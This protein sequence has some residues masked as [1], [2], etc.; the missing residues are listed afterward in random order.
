LSVVSRN[1]E[2]RDPQLA[3]ALNPLN[4]EAAINLVVGDLNGAT[5]PNLAALAETATRLISIAPA[6]ARGY[7]ILGAVEDR[8]GDK[9]RAEALYQ[10]ALLHSKSELHALLSLAQMRLDEADT[11]AALEYIDLLLRRWP[12]YFESAQVIL[13]AAAADPKA[14]G[15]LEQKLN[16]TP[17]WR[18]TAIR[19]LAQDKSSLGML[20]K[21]IA[22][23]P[24]QARNAPAWLFER[25]T[26]VTALVGLEA[27]AEAYALFLS[28]LT[29]AEARVSAYVFDGGFELPL[30]RSFFGWRVQ[31]PGATEVKT[32]GMDA[33]GAAGLRVR[34]LDSPAR[35]AIVSQ[36]IVLPF[37][38]YKLAVEASAASL[39]APKS[40]FWTVTCSKGPTLG[41]L[42]VPIGT[43]SGSALELE[44]D[45]PPLNC[46]RQILSLDTAVRTESWRDRYQGEV[47]FSNLAITR[48]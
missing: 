21:L 42:N 44:I 28:T 2:A 12:S 47:R 45:V 9:P 18:S 41:T 4:S 24:D 3:L 25:D 46:E 20:R 14:A 38:R 40:L 39:T 7:S 16:E 29:E 26:V 33:A 6:D 32:G 35:P 17:P 30:G 8:R 36:N 11:A 15:I 31:K 13:K 5:T 19:L 34:F 43:Y 23:A 27:Y 10:T 48:L 1:N 37:G 22:T